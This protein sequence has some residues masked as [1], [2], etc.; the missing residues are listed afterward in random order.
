MGFGNFAGAW[1]GAQG[2]SEEENEG[3][4]LVDFVVDP[5][6]GL[7]DSKV[8]PLLFVQETA[9]LHVAVNGLG[10]EHVSV[11]ELVVL[12]LLRVLDLVREV[13]HFLFF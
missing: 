5:A 6:A 3:L 9:S 11:L 10:Q 8:A 4:G 12:V 7:L 1:V 2:A 13:R